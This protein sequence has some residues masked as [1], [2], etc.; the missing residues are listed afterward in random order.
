[1]DENLNTTAVN[2]DTTPQTEPVEG[3]A[4]EAD[5]TPAENTNPEQPTGTT[6]E[7]E[8]GTDDPQPPDE[9]FLPVDFR[10]GTQRTGEQ[11]FLNRADAKKYAQLGLLREAEQ[12][13]L[14]NLALIAAGRGMSTAEFVRSLDEEDKADLM[15]DKLNITGGNREA[16]EVLMQDELDKRREALNLRERQKQEAEEAAEQSTLDRLAGE[17]LEL[18]ELVPE[19]ADWDAIPQTV[20][21]D[22][23]KN[24]RNLTDAYLRYMHSE[25]KK[26]EQ[27]RATA[28]TAAAASTGSQADHPPAGEMDPASAAIRAS[29]RSV[30][31]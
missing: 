17:L 27:N 2:E 5:P 11:R 18:Q 31:N 1:M 3:A 8:G 20:K 4:P 10:H 22:A 15:E 19:L 26:I 23:I 25:A 28:A 24:N 29:V 7:A 16:A 14:D 6:P 13:M 30:F 12:P 9:K 21:E